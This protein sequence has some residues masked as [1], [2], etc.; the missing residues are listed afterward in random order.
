MA[1]RGWP[2]RVALAQF[3]MAMRA[4]K[5]K[6]GKLEP[7]IA[8]L[9]TYGEL[10][11]KKFAR[12]CEPK[13]VRGQAGVERRKRIKARDDYTCQACGAVEHKPIVVLEIDHIVPL[14]VSHDES[15]DNLQA[16][17]RDCH[18]M[19]TAAES[20][21][22]VSSLPEWLPKSL[23][24]VIVVCGPP[25]AGKSTY[26]HARAN[27]CDL[28]LDTDEIAARSTGK[29]IYQATPED[30]DAAIRYRNTILARLSRQR[31]AEL[32]ERCWLVASASTARARAFWRKR[33]TELIVL[34]PGIDECVRRIDAD[35]RRPEAVRA[36]HRTAAMLWERETE[37]EAA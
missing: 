16:L 8:T 35:E 15:D 18:A 37:G 26:V 30:I 10:S 29:P 17:C 22:H 27:S 2:R 33:A 11:A 28:I 1:A 36:R 34:D 20:R 31:D 23:I 9:V 3:Q 24:P 13:R 6:I 19:K 12:R 7:R 5:H 32:Y 14:S 25:G 21:S 4:M